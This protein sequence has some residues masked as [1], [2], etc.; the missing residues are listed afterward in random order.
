MREAP[1]KS[2]VPAGGSVG[3]GLLV[4][5]STKELPEFSLLFE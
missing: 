1:G 4:P 5:V 3:K 2:L